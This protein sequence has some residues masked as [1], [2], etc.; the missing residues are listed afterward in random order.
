MFPSPQKHFYAKLSPILHHN[1]SNY[2]PSTKNVMLGSPLLHMAYKLH[3][4]SNACGLES[5][6]AHAFAFY[7]EKYSSN[8]E[9]PV[10]AGNITLSS[11][12]NCHNIKILSTNSELML[13]IYNSLL[14]ILHIA[15]TGHIGLQKFTWPALPH[16]QAFIPDFFS[17]TVLSF[18]SAH[19]LLHF[20]NIPL[21]NFP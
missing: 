1:T 9:S 21:Q 12:W 2:N 7:L 8:L 13:F 6:H 17:M 3:F 14:I 10:S 19:T 11:S 4:S 15:H 20:H 16:V 5:P 18:I